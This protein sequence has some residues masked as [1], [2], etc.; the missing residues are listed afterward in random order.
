MTS[1]VEILGA[2]NIIDPAS[3]VRI[4]A[5]ADLELAAAATLL[6]ME[7]GGGRNVWGHDGVDPGGTYVKGSAVTREAYT[8]YLTIRGRLGAQGCG[9]AQ[10]TWPGFQDRADRLGG[11]WRWDVNC[12]VGFEILADLIHL[13]G[14]RDGF[15]RYNGSGPA[16]V[17]YAQ[18]AMRLYDGWQRKL[19]GI[20]GDPKPGW[21]TSR[22]GDTG[23]AVGVI[24]RFLAVHPVDEIFGPATA[25]AV[26]KYQAMRGLVADGIVGPATWA[27]TGL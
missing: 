19:G 6:Q 3:V 17:A 5:A 8:A 13:H 1:A 15:R 11:C 27:A 20:G 4:A 12:R 24:Q 14:V 9:P 26:K 22:R 2:G 25:A 7:S 21:P 23:T 10:L 16:A 18:K